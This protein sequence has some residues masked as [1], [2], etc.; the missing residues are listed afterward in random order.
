MTKTTATRVALAAGILGVIGGL[1]TIIGGRPQGWIAIV[2]GAGM[3]A[4][5]MVESRRSRP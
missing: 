1:I 3:V 4:L 5:V 2:C